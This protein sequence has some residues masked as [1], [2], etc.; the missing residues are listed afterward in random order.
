MLLMKQKI[1]SL[2]FRVLLESRGLGNL[3]WDF[4]FSLGGV[5]F[6]SRDFCGF[7]WKP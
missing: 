6:W 4:F 3:E 5:N 2:V 1:M 7:C